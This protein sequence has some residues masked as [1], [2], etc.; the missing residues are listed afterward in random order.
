M[1]D[2]C[3][4]RGERARAAEQEAERD[5][6]TRSAKSAEIMASDIVRRRCTLTARSEETAAAPER[7]GRRT[8]TPITTADPAVIGFMSLTDL[9]TF[10]ASALG[11]V[12][13]PFFA[14]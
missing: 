6:A 11:R 7:R 10:S 8:I 2:A 12:T 1:Q 13:R 9:R 14:R 5:Q 3:F 4:A